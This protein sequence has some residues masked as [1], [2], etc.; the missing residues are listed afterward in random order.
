MQTFHKR[1]RQ[2]S[3]K[4]RIAGRVAT[5]CGCYRSD[6]VRDASA[7]FN[8]LMNSHVSF[9]C[10]TPGFLAYGLHNMLWQFL[11]H[12]QCCLD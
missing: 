12:E 5:Q 10:F 6:V 2:L 11:G 8:A 7:A 3:S 4:R 1:A 9:S